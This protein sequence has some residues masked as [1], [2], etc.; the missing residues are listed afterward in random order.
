MSQPYLCI[1][2]PD[3]ACT[4]DFL[5]FSPEKGVKVE[6]V[7]VTVSISYE[8]GKAALSIYVVDDATATILFDEIRELAVEEI[9]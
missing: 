5:P 6:G 9:E 4:I 7:T 1:E 2:Q 3:H 8:S